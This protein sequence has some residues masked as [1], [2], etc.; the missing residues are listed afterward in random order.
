[1]KEK[2]IVA[3]YHQTGKKSIPIISAQIV[4]TRNETRWNLVGVDG[5][6]YGN[7]ANRKVRFPERLPNGIDL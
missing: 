3:F 2:K 1:M 7:V 4:N 5:T 6:H